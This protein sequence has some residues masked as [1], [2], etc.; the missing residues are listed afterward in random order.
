M[1]VPTKDQILR[2]LRSGG[3]LCGKVKV[4]GDKSISHRAALLN[5]IA[6]GPSH[7][8]NFCMGDDRTSMLGC[9][10][11]LGVDIEKHDNCQISESSECFKIHGSGL[12]GLTEP[13]DIL[14]AGNSCNTIRLVSGLLA[15]LN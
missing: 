15:G 12:H 4:P 13:E 10:K 1:K 5:S 7:V 14:N 6:T 2:N 3:E 8:S 9:L 11:G